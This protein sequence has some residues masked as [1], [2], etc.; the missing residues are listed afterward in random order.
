[1][2]ETLKSFREKYK[3]RKDL[4]IQVIHTD[5]VHKMMVYYEEEE[6][7]KMKSLENFIN[8]MAEQ[9]IFS[10]ILVYKKEITSSAKKVCFFL[11]I[12]NLKSFVVILI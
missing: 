8:L 7:I 10:G 6:K 12:W 9:A 4:I 2:N 1:M 3:D 11:A 5:G